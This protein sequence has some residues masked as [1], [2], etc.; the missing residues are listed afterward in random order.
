MTV[1]YRSS[2]DTADDRPV[3][4]GTPESARAR[5]E[6]NDTRALP[7]RRERLLDVGHVAQIGEDLLA[8]ALVEGADGADHLHFIGND[9]VADATVDRTE[10]QHRRLFA[11]TPDLHWVTWPGMDG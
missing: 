1:N 11:E 8:H 7:C 3:L 6:V 5:R 4:G 2:S 9:V 10:G